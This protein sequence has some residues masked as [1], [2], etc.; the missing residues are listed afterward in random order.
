MALTLILGALVGMVLGLTGAGGGILAVPVL[1]AGM[2][3]SVSQASPVALIA[4]ATGAL[5]GSL[6]GWRRGWV[7]YRAALLM[8]VCGLPGTVLGLKLSQ[9]WPAALLQVLFALTML[10][11]AAR[12]WQQKITDVQQQVICHLNPQTGRIAWNLPTGM[13]IAAVGTLTG[14]LTGLLGVGGG[15]VIVPALRRWSDLS[16]HSIVATSL[17]I[18][19]LVSG[20]GVVL[21]WWHGAALSG[22]VALP[23]A[24]AVVAGMLGG[25]LLAPHFSG[26]QVQRGF[27]LLLLLVAL[28]M[29]YKVTQ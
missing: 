21:A 12:L 8:A 3:W 10:V 29:F 9:N 2:G 6:D 18:I 23:F 17:L 4:V 7:R 14:L 5:V 16:M 22:R 1:M 20:S 26:R 19:T 13:A 24:A 28:G 15:F 25:R 11:V 27:A